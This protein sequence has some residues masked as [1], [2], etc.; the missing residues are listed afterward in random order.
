LSTEFQEKKT[1]KIL[2]RQIKIF[3]FLINQ[4]I[5]TV[6]VSTKKGLLQ[7]GLHQN[8]HVKKSCTLQDLPV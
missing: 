5:G 7:N 4:E 3:N 6:E 8:G 1:S 2:S